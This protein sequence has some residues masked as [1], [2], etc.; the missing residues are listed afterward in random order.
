MKTRWLPWAF[1]AC[2]VLA[3][4][5][6]ALPETLGSCSRFSIAARREAAWYRRG[7]KSLPAWR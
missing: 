6:G 7:A 1:L 3:S 2:P 4:D 5:R